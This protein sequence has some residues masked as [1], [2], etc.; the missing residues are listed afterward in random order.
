MEATEEGITTDVREK[1][2]E[3]AFAPIE[4]TEEGMATDLSEEQPAKALYPMAQT[5]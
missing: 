5:P 1:Q 3:K 2:S 4:V